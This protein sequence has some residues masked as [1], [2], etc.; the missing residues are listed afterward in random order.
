MTLYKGALSD[1]TQFNINL[2]WSLLC[3]QFFFPL[4]KK[5]PSRTRNSLFCLVSPMDPSACLCVIKQPCLL[6]LL[7]NNSLV[8]WGGQA[9]FILLCTHSEQARCLSLLSS[10]WA[11]LPCSTSTALFPFPH[12]GISATEPKHKS[13]G[14]Q[15]T[16][17][18]Q[19]ILGTQAMQI[20]QIFLHLITWLQWAHFLINAIWQ[21]VILHQCIRIFSNYS[22]L[23]W[24]CFWRKM[25]RKQYLCFVFNSQPCSNRE[26][27][28]DT[29]IRV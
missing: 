11:L 24:Q 5:N 2:K 29:Q 25:R 14:I 15:A 8:S 17:A 26:R 1:F 9:G 13:P 19:T 28:R 27:R 4:E 12:L 3:I 20:H 16:A 23:I 10:A 22:M 21:K 6:L 7:V 18:Q